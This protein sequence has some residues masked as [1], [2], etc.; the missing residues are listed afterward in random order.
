MLLTACKLTRQ[1]NPCKI[2]NLRELKGELEF[3]QMKS[4]EATACFDKIINDF[5]NKQEKGMNCLPEEIYNNMLNYCLC[6][7]EIR[8]AMLLVCMANWGMRF[9]DLVRVRFGYLFD[10]KTGKII[11]KFSLPNGEKKTGK[12]VVYYNNTATKKI[13]GLYLQQPCNSRKTRLDFLFTSESYNS[14][15]ASVKDLEASDLYDFDIEKTQKQLN[16][17]PDK[18]KQLLNKFIEGKISDNS[19]ARM[20]ELIA[21]E[22]VKLNKEISNLI[23][24]KNNYI[25]MTPNAE[26]IYI[27]I[28]ISHQAGEDIVKNTLKK[29]GV[30]PR[31]CKNKNGEQTTNEKYNTHSMRKIFG[32]WF[33]SVGESLKISG[34]LHFDNTILNLLV[35]KF[36]H[37]NSRVT[38]HYTDAQQKAFETIC[39]NLNIGLDVINNYIYGGI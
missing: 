2:I 26:N 20:K 16:K 19:Y 25:S 23:Y 14:P 37:S 7:G 22:K 38:A 35:E 34:E 6:N 3:E 29:I 10:E 32:D 4:S 15:K 33:L 12:E 5:K 28:P 9:S 18:E 13:I 21:E 27:Q 39:Y 17:I 31:N 36:M 11:D 24:K 1:K 8:N 30:I